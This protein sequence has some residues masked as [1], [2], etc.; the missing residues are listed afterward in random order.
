[1]RALYECKIGKMMIESATR[2]D[3]SEAILRVEYVD[4]NS[5]DQSH[6]R[7]GMLA[8]SP[9]IN[10]CAREFDEY[11]EGQRKTF[12]VP[13]MLVGTPFREKCWAQLMCIPYGEK[14][15]YGEM[16]RRVGNSKASRAVGG[17]NHHNPVNIIVPCHRVI[18]ADGS[19]GGYGGGLWRKEWLLA[20]ED[21][22]KCQD[23]C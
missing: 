1:M 17:A 7:A 19:L 16:A 14:I 12:D 21:K 18:A 9:V 8:N 4:E 2:P 15:S 10:Q 23:G 6:P 13:L 20:W 5:L 11:F 22:H 3:G